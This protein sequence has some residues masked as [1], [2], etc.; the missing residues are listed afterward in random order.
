M[1]RASLKFFACASFALLLSIQSSQA[2]T[3]IKLDLGGVGPDVA[4]DGAVPTIL[5]TID[6][7]PPGLAGDQATNILFTSFLSGLGSTSGSYSLSGAQSV[8]APNII[9]PSPGPGIPPVVSQQFINGNFQL[10]DN[11]N[12]LLLSVGLTSS[13]LVGS[14]NGAFFNITN[15]VVLGGL[16]SITSQ[17]VGNSIGMSLT[18]TNIN[19]PLGPGLAIT[20]GGALAPFVGDAT[21]EITATQ[22]PEPTA[23]MLLVVGGLLF[24]ALLRRR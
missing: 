21:K 6:D 7:N 9:V 5:R 12:T 1:M 24:P 11:S 8:G 3:I 19:N 18:L 23:A 10:Y 13:V 22:A 2:A 4:Y 15:G 14:N 20:P 16:P 17:L